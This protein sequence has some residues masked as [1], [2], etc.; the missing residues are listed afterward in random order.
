M[1]FTLNIHVCQSYLSQAELDQ[2]REQLV[3]LGISEFSGSNA[4]SQLCEAEEDNYQV[5]K[6]QVSI[7]ALRHIILDLGK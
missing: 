1:K 5:R 3:E 4:V 7:H 6:D 2:V